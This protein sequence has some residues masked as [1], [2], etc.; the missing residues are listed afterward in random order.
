MAN[1]A[2]QPGGEGELTWLMVGEFSSMRIR[3]EADLAMTE[4]NVTVSETGR[5]VD[6]T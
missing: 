1:W 2:I 6:H 4:W 3:G 5:W